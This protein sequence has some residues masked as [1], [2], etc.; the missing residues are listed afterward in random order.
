MLSAVA[1]VAALA[2]LLAFAPFASAA[3][4]PI[5]SGTTTV[6]LNKGFV[7]KLKNKQREGAQ[8]EP[9]EASKAAP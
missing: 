4:D 1:V 7:K 6:T 8:G 9:R 3:S 5:A 2:A